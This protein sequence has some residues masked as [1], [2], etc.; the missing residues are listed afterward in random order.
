MLRRSIGIT[1]VAVVVAV[2]VARVSAQS[3]PEVLGS[4]LTEVRGLRQAIEQMAS[5]GARVQLALGRLQLQ[6]QRVNT[7]L[8]RQEALRGEIAAASGRDRTVRESIVELEEQIRSITDPVGKRASEYELLVA[9]KHAQKIAVE[10]Q[11]LQ[12]EETTLASQI[13][14][15]QGRWLEINR[16]LEELERA[17]TRR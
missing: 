3:G 17:L 8:R 5:S 12:T 9:R 2:V 15:E 13:A 10:L 7:M 1:L 16:S 4:L 11:Q 6:E 14:G